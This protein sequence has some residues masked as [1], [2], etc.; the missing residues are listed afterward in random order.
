MPR[1]L[2]ASASTTATASI[3]LGDSRSASSGAH[4]SLRSVTRPCSPAM[5]TTSRRRIRSSLRTAPANTIEAWSSRAMASERPS[6][7]ISR[8]SISRVTPSARAAG[9]SASNES[10]GVSTQKCS[11]ASI[12]RRTSDGSVSGPKTCILAAEDRAPGG[13]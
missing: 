11:P 9:W 2:S 1:R 10:S 8:R 12:A 4:G 7:A 5:I 6:R 13:R 3:S